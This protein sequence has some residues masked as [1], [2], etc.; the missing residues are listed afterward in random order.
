MNPTSNER[1]ICRYVGRENMC[2][3]EVQYIAQSGT[4]GV[5][6]ISR[7]FKIIGLFWKRAL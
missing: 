6:T 2:I 3:H 1:L 5:A 4:Y 7:L